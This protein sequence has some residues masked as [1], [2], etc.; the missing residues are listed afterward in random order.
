MKAWNAGLAL[1]LA[2]GSAGADEVVLANGGKVQG[3]VLSKSAD[4]VTV[5]VKVGTVTFKSKDVTAINPGRTDLHEFRD[6]R[7]ALGESPKASDLFALAQWAD[8]KGLSRNGRELCEQVVRSEPDHAGARGML[9]H[10]KSGARWLTRDEAKLAKGLRP[11]DGRWVTSAEAE[12]AEARR[13]EAEERRLD[14]ERERA[15][16]AEELR[17]RRE[18]AEEAHRMRL[19][20]VLGGL[21]GYF[22]SPSFAFTTPYFRPYGWA[23]YARSRG[24]YQEGWR[25]G[26]GY[27]PFDVLDLVR[28]PIKVP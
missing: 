22:Y 16:R 10:E 12:L 25:T 13:L 17:R 3:V 23:T 19:E 7:A 18:A 15:A 1:L 5:E 4:A 24:M 11:M 27:V 20:A 28:R 6:R 8:R 21:D 2:A 26:S 14:R 9:G